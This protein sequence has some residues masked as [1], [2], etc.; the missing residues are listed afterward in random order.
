MSP[1]SAFPLIH[2]AESSLIQQSK[3][4]LTKSATAGK[5]VNMSLLGGP[6]QGKEVNISLR[7]VQIAGIPVTRRLEGTRTKYLKR[8]ASV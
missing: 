3:Q 1:F 5:E 8:A 6:L 2:A 4:A 7:P